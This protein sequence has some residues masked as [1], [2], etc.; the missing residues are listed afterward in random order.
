VGVNRI[1]ME[2]FQEAWPKVGNDIWNLQKKAYAK[3]KALN[4]S[5]QTLIPKQREHNVIAH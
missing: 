2:F 4:I 5:L 3:G 1:P